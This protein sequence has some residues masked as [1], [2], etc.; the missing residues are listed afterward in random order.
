MLQVNDGTLQTSKPTPQKF[1]TV[2]ATTIYVCVCVCFLL[3]LLL[4]F[5]FLLLSCFSVHYFNLWLC[6][7]KE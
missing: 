1:S 7:A 2:A 5:V 6:M 4:F 3:L